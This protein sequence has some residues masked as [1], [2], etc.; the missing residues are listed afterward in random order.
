MIEQLGLGE[1]VG[2]SGW[3]SDARRYIC[4]TGGASFLALTSDHEGF[5]MALCEAIVNG[6]SVVG[7]DCS[8]GLS[9]IVSDGVNGVLVP[10]APTEKETIQN[11]AGAFSKVADGKVMFDEALVRSSV[12]AYMR[13]TVRNE[14]EELLRTLEKKGR[15]P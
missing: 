8:V 5:P 6:L 13:S 3:K 12:N 10:F 11:I 4:D 9:A 1:Q 2:I 14:W 15:L 7:L